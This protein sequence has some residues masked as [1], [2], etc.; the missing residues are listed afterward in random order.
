[1][2]ATTKIFA[3][4][5]V[6]ILLVGGLVAG[7]F[8]LGMKK[9]A[10]PSAMTSKPA[11][12]HVAT[13]PASAPATT[14]TPT[15]AA[16]TAAG[17]LRP[18]VKAPAGHPTI[19]QG[20][21]QNRPVAQQA[22]PSVVKPGIKFSHFRVGNRNVKDML[23]DG[24]YVWVGTSGGVIRYDTRSDDY[25][26]FD[27]R[28]GSLLANG[29]FHV[30]KLSK[31]R[32]SVGTYGGGWSI[33]DQEKGTWKSY[34][35]PHGLAD[36][37]VYDV[38]EL[39]NG[40]IWVATWSGANRIRGGDMDDRS[41]W[42]LFTVENTS[43][44]LPNDWVYGLAAGK[45]GDIWV[46]TEGGLALFREDTWQHWNHKDGLGVAYDK[47]KDQEQFGSDPGKTSSHHAQQKVEQGLGKVTTAY[48]PNYIISLEVDAEGIVWCG[49]WGGGLARFDGSQ[50]TNFT[51]TEGLPSNY[52]F[53]LAQD[54]EQNLWIG[55]S[56]GLVRREKDG[57]KVLDTTDGLFSNN[58][59]SMTFAA[60]KTMWVGSFGGVARI[61]PKQG[62]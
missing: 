42:D 17:P 35:I 9:G 8:M 62:D 57:F 61:F 46:A 56:K 41:K 24:P 38:L 2:N 32:I 39:P 52:I 36:A 19:P 49:T 15:G 28:N 31:N 30:G 11:P 51:M 47:V 21:T 43:G 37:F 14:G 16:R 50:W 1:M 33:Y 25:K 6:A 3:F 53:M 58:V 5:I 45:N 13:A 59:F 54:A 12:S 44:G 55:T 23:A 4:A 34:N 48:N 29:V 26:L 60:D 22:A 18:G 7:A 27:V 10:E 20:H 40:D